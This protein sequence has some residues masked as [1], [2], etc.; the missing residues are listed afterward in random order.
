H[1]ADLVVLD[2]DP[3]ADIANTRAIHGVM[4]RGRWLPE[5]DLAVARDT[6]AAVY[7]GDASRFAGVPFPFAQPEFSTVFRAESQF[8]SG[9]ERFSWLGSSSLAE[10]RYAGEGDMIWELELGPAG[11]GTSLHVVEDGLELTATRAGGRV[12]VTGRFGADTSIAVDEPIADD[13][14]LG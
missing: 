3:L 13:E 2:A 8:A 5:H 11:T 9:E 12:K 14:L 4:L 1:R 7:K 6:I 10:P